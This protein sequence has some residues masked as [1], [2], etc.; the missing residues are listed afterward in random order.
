MFCADTISSTL[1]SSPLEVFNVIGSIYLNTGN[2]EHHILTRDQKKRRYKKGLLM[3]LMLTS[4]VDMFSMLVCFLLQTF[5]TTPEIM[6]TKGVQLPDAITGKEIKE[7]SVLSLT[8]DELFLDQKS[9]GKT[10]AIL[11]NPV[12]FVRRL[13]KLKKAWAKSNPGKPF[14]GEIN[15]QADR[16]VES[17]VVAQLMGILTGQNYGVI[18]L[19]V[20]SGGQGHGKGASGDEAT[21]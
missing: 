7:A 11:K 12:P 10:L 15:F 13:K 5:S 9:V 16:E 17:V 20:V 3:A 19:A 2:F 4:M 18:Q 14:T 8:K 6:V 1:V 21:D